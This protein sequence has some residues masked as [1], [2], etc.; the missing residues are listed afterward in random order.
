MGGVTFLLGGWTPLP[1][2]YRI[3]AEF[4]P[5]YLAGYRINTVFFGENLAKIRKKSGI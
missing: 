5:D 4:L 1:T 2:I 3:F